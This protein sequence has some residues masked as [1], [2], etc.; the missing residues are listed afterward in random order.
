MQPILVLQ[1]DKP[2]VSTIKPG[3]SV[4]L[5]MLALVL[6]QLADPGTLTVTLHPP[7]GAL[8]AIITDLAPVRDST[9]TFHSDQIIPIG[10][11]AGIWVERWVST[12]SSASLSATAEQV[13]SVTALDF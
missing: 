2:A 7:K 3:Q 8:D 10:A 12:G 11:T 1:L 5:N 9:G 4:R 6:G 13:W